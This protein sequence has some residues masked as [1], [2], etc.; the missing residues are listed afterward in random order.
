MNILILGTSSQITRSLKLLIGENYSIKRSKFKFIYLSY[1]NFRK[2]NLY[3]KTYKPI[4]IINTMVYHPVDLC[5]KNFYS[6][7]KGNV[8]VNKNIIFNIKK[9]KNYFPLLIFFSSDYVYSS[10]D[11]NIKFK[12]SDILKPI[13]IL[14]MHKQNTESFISNNY[15]NFLILRVSWLFSIYGKNFVKTMINL[16]LNKDE[17]S[18]VSDQIGN[19]TSA[20]FVASILI[21]IFLSKRKIS[22]GIINLSN[23]PIV[24]WYQFANEIKNNLKLHKKKFKNTTINKITSKQYNKIFDIT[25]KR[26]I[27]S[28]M[29]LNKM[30]SIFKLSN[31]QINWK[32][33]LNQDIAKLLN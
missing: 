12:E 1:I 20:R 6:S 2:L 18:V 4:I 10:D 32:K 26:P 24:S 13:N 28:S 21:Q 25:T 16:L 19:P 8:L 22:R 23:Y 17:I 11:T 14:G 9:Y 30:K 31:D 5:E 27:N 29:D 33:F 7:Y 3:I 15:K